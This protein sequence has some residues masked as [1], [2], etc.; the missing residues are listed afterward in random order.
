MIIAEREI[1]LNKRKSL[2]KCAE[3]HLEAKYI[4]VVKH[5]KGGHTLWDIPSYAAFPCAIQNELTE[6]DAQNFVANGFASIADGANIA[7]FKKV[8]DAMIVKGI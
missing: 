2:T 8:A 1:K 6:V 5:P 4:S 7:G 3:T